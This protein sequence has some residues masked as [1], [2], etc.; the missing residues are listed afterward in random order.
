MTGEERK[1]S[2]DRSAGW[3][4]TA[5]GALL[6]VAVGFGVGLVAGTAYQE[7]ELV[8]EHLAGHTIEVPLAQPAPAP[9]PEPDPDVAAP[10][11]PAVPAAEPP[12][13]DMAE[14]AEDPLPTPL[15]AGGLDKPRTARVAPAAPSLVPSAHAPASAP[16]ARAGAKAAAKGT[17]FAIQVGAFATESTAQQLASEL[18]RRGFRSYVTEVGTG[19]RFKVRVGPIGSRSEAEQLSGRLKSQHRLPTWILA[20]K[21]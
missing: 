8:A 11:P 5:L 19:A 4:A 13:A 15:G 6:L 3:L 2:Q 21:S 12:A 20:E 17:G 10:P 9:V 1:R 14:R 7:P 18:E 16:P